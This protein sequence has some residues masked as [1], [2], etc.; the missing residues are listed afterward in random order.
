MGVIVITCFKP[1]EGM[2]NELLEVIK[3]HIPVLRKEGLVTDRIC[4]VMRSSNGSILE[5]FEWKSQ[6]AIENAHKNERV[7]ELWKRFE[8]ACTYEKLSSLEES[9][10][11][12]PGF[13]PVEF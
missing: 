13:E 5:V 4:H 7:L 11:M 8:K 12:F 9:N 2:E 6:E 10:M 1:K 3:D